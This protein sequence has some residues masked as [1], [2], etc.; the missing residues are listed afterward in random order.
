MILKTI[1]MKKQLL[2][3]TMLFASSTLF[4]QRVPCADPI[5]R[6]FDFWVGEW[7]AYGVNG[8]KAGDSKISVILDSCTILEE[9][10]STGVNNSFRYA[11]KSFNTYNATSGQWQQTWI[12][13][14]AGS[15]EFLKG[16]ASDGKIVFQTNPFNF[17]KDTMG[18]RKLSFFKLDAN[19][20]RQLGEL[21]KDDGKTWATEY[22]FEYR[23]KTTASNI[24]I[25]KQM[26]AAFNEHDWKKMASFYSN[27]CTFL[28]PAYGEKHVPQTHDDMLKHYGGLQGWSPDV[29]DDITFI[30][31]VGDNKVLIQ[32]TSSGT[33]AKEKR[34]WSLPLC[35]VLTLENGK[36]V[37]DEVYYDKD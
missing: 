3:I 34:K 24:D 30:T 33:T 32:F 31:A 2:L 13:N 14:S 36:I 5:Y 6:Q 18:I 16:V 1:K 25:V 26:F 19:K 21:S 10:T 23:R 22:D 7:D 4:S 20:V 27:P 37:K 35:T 12:D 11:G 28:D 15:I 29:R 17:S 9:W 8:K